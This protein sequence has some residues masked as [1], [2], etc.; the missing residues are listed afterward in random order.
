MYTLAAM[1]RSAGNEV[2]PALAAALD[3]S[4]L[5]A[6][7]GLTV[8]LLTV[9]ADGWPRLA[10]LSAGEVLA[11]G[12]RALRL[13]LWPDS[14]TTTNLDRSDRATL[15]AVLDGAGWYLRCTASRQPDL[16]LPG[17]R[18]LASFGLT[19]DETLEDQVPYAELTTGIGFRLLEPDRVLPAWREAVAAM[20]AAGEG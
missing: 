2:P 20:R 15:A 6:A 5:E 19:V 9:D 16:A 3:G 10:M 1:S 8:L 11:T 7:A 12:A 18:R 17:G 14:R 4:R 13:A